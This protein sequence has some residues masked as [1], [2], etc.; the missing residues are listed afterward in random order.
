[1]SQKVL[2]IDLDS[3]IRCHACEIA[4]RQEHGLTY[5]TKSR[6]CRVITVGPRSIQQELH[7]D[8]IPTICFQCDDPICAY[9]CPVDAISKRE[10]GMV[11]IDEKACT[12][13]KLCV[14][15]CPYGSIF[16]DETKGITGKCNL[17]MS[18]IHHGIEPTCVQHCIGG[19]LQYVTQEELK[20]IT[21]GEHLLRM[22]LV[23]YV[24]SKWKLRNEKVNKLEDREV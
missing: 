24:S 4:C 3:C 22:G 6:W 7:M 18:R 13:C 20:D 9:F 2:L 19:A 8:F 17:C 14:Y 11:V 23:Y 10:D 16:F 1:V 5:E 12:G 21:S 15:G